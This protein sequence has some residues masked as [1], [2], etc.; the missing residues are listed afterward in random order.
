MIIICRKKQNKSTNQLMFFIKNKIRMI[1]VTFGN[2][3][4]EFTPTS[5][6][7]WQAEHRYI[8]HTTE[9]CQ[10]FLVL[11]QYRGIL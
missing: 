5:R 1:S 8:L 4:S 6:R 2:Q 11:R 3:Q 7:D 9:S 10:M